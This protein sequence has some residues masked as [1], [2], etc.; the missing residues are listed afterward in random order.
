MTKIH[1]Y[2]SFSKNKKIPVKYNR[3]KSK[4]YNLNHTNINFLN[5]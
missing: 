1:T 4:K 3:F 2:T 5:P